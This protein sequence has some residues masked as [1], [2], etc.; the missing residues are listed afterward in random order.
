MSHVDAALRALEADRQ[1]VPRPVPTELD[2]RHSVHRGL[3]R[4]AAESSVV[5]VERESRDGAATRE[6]P[7]EMFVAARGRLADASSSTRLLGPDATAVQVEQFR[8]L[9]A[10]LHDAQIQ[11]G[12][13]TV[14]VTSA[15]PREGKTLTTLN[16]GLTLSES[17]GRCV[18]VVDADLRWPSIHE[19]LGVRN[20][21]GLSDALRDPSL[22]VPLVQLSPTWS[23]LPAGR[24]GSSPLA[25]LT[26]ERMG[27]LLE[28]FESRF[29]WILIDTPPVGFLPDARLLARLI[30]SVVVVVRAGSTPARVAEKAIAEL[31]PECILGCVLNGVEDAAIPAADYYGYGASSEAQRSA[32]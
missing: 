16:L 31:G 4:F 2:V 3:D 27:V 8:R 9:A 21:P 20:T 29:D 13:K 5:G 17:Y 12:I 23:V 11:H 18:L 24:S 26:S 30:Q 28:E 14:M 15:V 1:V 10:A 22:E 6:L 25:G 32:Q 19:V 7:R